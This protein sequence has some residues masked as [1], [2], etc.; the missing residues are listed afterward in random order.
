MKKS[1]QVLSLQTTFGLTVQGE[2]TTCGSSIGM[3]GTNAFSQR[4]H[5]DW[6]KTSLRANRYRPGD[7]LHG[8]ELARVVLMRY[9]FVESLNQQSVNYLEGSFKGKFLLVSPIRL[10]L[11]IDCRKHRQNGP[12]HIY[13]RWLCHP[14]SRHRYCCGSRLLFILLFLIIDFLMPTPVIWFRWLRR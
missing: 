12:R 8:G 4:D 13:H 14:Q 5:L 2:Q 11:L 6:S 3:H 10:E 9:F 1:Q 7:K